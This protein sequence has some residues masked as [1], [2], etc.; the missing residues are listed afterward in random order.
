MAKRT[1]QE[2]LFE[3]V[4]TVLGAGYGISEDR[5]QPGTV[6]DAKDLTR[7]NHMGMSLLHDLYGKDHFHTKEFEASTESWTIQDLQRRIGVLEAV[8]AAIQ[9][10][11]YETTRALIAAELFDDFLEMAAH[12]VAEGYKDAAAVIAGTSL[13]THLRRLAPA[14]TV[15]VNGS[16][17]EPKKAELLNAELHKTGAYTLS[18]QKQVTAWL[19]IRNDAAHGH[20]DKVLSGAVQ[21]MI[22]GVIH[23]INVHPA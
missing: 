17:G 18:E 23:F 16:K 10:G 8:S 12:L 11:W 1:R 9:G 3:R 20:Y 7:F 14:W 19:G 15:D 21:V 6:D 22:D 13:E 2:L 4:M 5:R